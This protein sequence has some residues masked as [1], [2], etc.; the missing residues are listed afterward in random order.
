MR[1]I[2]T[3]SKFSSLAC[4]SLFDRSKL[5]AKGDANELN[6]EGLEVQK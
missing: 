4:K 2:L 1:F 3:G 6:F 5:D